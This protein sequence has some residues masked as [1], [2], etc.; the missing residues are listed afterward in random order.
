MTLQI[1]KVAAQR[2]ESFVDGMGVMFAAGHWQVVGEK[3]FAQFWF[4]HPEDP[5][6]IFGDEEAAHRQATVFVVAMQNA[7]NPAAMLGAVIEADFHKG[8]EE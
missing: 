4:D 8:C 7:G 2:Y 6:K 3:T 5:R 1:S